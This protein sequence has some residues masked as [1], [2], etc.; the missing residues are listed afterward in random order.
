MHKITRLL[1][2]NKLNPSLSNVLDITT[3]NGKSIV[4]VE[5]NGIKYML[6]GLI[7]TI[8]TE[9]IQDKIDDKKLFDV[10]KPRGWH[11]MA[12]FVDSEGNVYFKGIEQPELK[13][14][15]SPTIL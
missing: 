7:K 4:Y 6:D 10:K 14:S 1:L 11:F 15:L 12:E 13:G 5:E 8:I 2:A 3:E 9:D